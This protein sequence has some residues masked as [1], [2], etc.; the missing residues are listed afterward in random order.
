MSIQVKFSITGKIYFGRSQVRDVAVK[1]LS[2]IDD[3]CKVFIFLMNH[4]H[5]PQSYQILCN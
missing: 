1:R 3:Y 4:V 2:H 5:Q